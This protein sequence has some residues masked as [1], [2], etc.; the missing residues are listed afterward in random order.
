MKNWKKVL[1]DRIAITGAHIRTGQKYEWLVHFCIF[2]FVLSGSSNQS[3]PN[4]SG[5]STFAK[6]CFLA[7]PYNRPL[8]KQKSTLKRNVR[9]FHPTN[10]TLFNLEQLERALKEASVNNGQ[11]SKSIDSR[12][13]RSSPE[14]NW[15][16][17]SS[18]TFS[19]WERVNSEHLI[20]K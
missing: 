8:Y 20:I 1:S 6:K 9:R 10:S 4:F 14:H 13:N 7:R 17:P 2:C 5:P 19:Q 12:Q 11:L 18:V 16:I 3:R 15:P